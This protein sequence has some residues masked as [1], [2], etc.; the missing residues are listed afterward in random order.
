MKEHRKATKATRI[1]TILFIIFLVT[2]FFLIKNY[3]KLQNNISEESD[4]PL[5][6]II[7][8]CIF[9]LVLWYW[10]ICNLIK[11]SQLKK[12]TKLREKWL[13][14][15]INTK[16]I[17]FDYEAQLA[18]WKGYYYIVT[19]NW[20]TEFSSES[21]KGTVIWFNPMKLLPL[22]NIWLKYDTSEI[23]K[24]LKELDEIQTANDVKNY[25]ENNSSQ[26][27]N[28]FSKGIQQV[29]E[30]VFYDEMLSQITECKEYLKEVSK[31]P[32]F[33]NSYLQHKSHQIHI[34]DNITVYI[35]PNNP[36]I[37][38]VDTDFLYN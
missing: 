22:R 29:S 16:I 33:K 25:I 10:I 38:Q 21:I 19:S 9:T 37:Y 14:Q 12:A 26:I 7:L 28:V 3:D 31:N 24:T 30:W 2:D 34:W 27:F 5:I 15:P 13:L 6:I 17:R 36:T 32:E 4:N 35:D 11:N 1:A 18:S 20:Q 8:W 23:E